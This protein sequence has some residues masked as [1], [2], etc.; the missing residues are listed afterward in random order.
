MWGH[1]Y[2]NCGYH[3]RVFH[4]YIF[5][6]RGSHVISIYWPSL[7]TGPQGIMKF[8][9]SKS[10]GSL[11]YAC[12]AW[13]VRGAVFGIIASCIFIGGASN[14]ISHCPIISGAWEDDGRFLLSKFCV[15]HSSSKVA[16]IKCTACIF[17]PA[18]DSPLF[19]LFGQ[20]IYLGFSLGRNFEMKHCIVF[21]ICCFAI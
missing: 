2:P 13:S 18:S 17:H 19:F 7:A 21:F 4:F 6:S 1:P 15:D 10:F 5:F 11:W 3:G 8:H 9:W 14:Y 16:V 20:F 12:L